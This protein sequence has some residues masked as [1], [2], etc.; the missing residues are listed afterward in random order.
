MNNDLI[1]RYV[2]AV[3]KRLP[4]K[5][6]ED[7]SV[8]LKTLIDDMLTERCKEIVPEEK[9]IRVVLTELGDPRELADKYCQN[10]K[11]SLISGTYY[12]AYK[13]VLKIVL[14]CVAFGITLAFI[15]TYLSKLQFQQHSLL[16]ELMRWLGMLFTG[17]LGGFGMVTLVFVFFEKAKIKINDGL[18]LNDLPPVPQKNEIIPKWE[19]IAGIVFSIVFFSILLFAP[20]VFCIIVPA[21]IDMAPIEFF[22]IAALRGTWYIIAVLAAAGIVKEIYRLIDGRYNKRVMLTTLITDA[23]SAIFSIWW[24]WDVNIINLEFINYVS[25]IGSSQNGLVKTIFPYFNYF[26]LGLILLA[27]VIDMVTVIVKALK[28]ERPSA[29]LSVQE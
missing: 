23:V 8:E 16:K 18:N 4:S 5:M 1:E 7:V 17:A 27:L 21:G 9:D 26:L 2:Y 28:N 11:N 22:N 6:R 20:S 19:S 3:I 12:S 15:I 29:V 10:E 25:S 13:L 24:L 14:I